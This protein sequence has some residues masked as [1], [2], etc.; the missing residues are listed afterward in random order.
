[1][2]RRRTKNAVRYRL[3]GGKI[4]VIV[5]AG[6]LIQLVE[7]CYGVPDTVVALHGGTVDVASE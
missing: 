7:L 4:D 3:N 2:R 6:A 1:M 5:A